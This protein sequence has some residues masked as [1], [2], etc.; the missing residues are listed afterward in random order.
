MNFLLLSCDQGF[1]Q[2]IILE[3]SFHIYAR[4]EVEKVLESDLPPSALSPGDIASPLNAA[5]PE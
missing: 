4:K 1:R 3:K 2:V 5:C